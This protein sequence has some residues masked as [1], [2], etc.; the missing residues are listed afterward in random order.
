MTRPARTVAVL[1]SNY[2][3]WK[4]YFDLIQDVDLLVCHDDVQFT[5]NDW[6]NR[7][8]TAQGPQWLTVTR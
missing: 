7:I 6:R 2:L 5:K 8:K 3:R 1:Q 4:G